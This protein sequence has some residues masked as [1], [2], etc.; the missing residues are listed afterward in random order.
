M[1]KVDPGILSSRKV[2]HPKQYILVTHQGR[3]NSPKTGS[4]TRPQVRTHLPGFW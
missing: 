1:L 3:L 4:A 2:D